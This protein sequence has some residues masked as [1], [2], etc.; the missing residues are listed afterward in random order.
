MGTDPG[1]NLGMAP[2][3]S[4]GKDLGLRMDKDPDWKEGKVAGLKD[5]DP[6]RRAD[7]VYYHP[8]NFHLESL[9]DHIHV[10]NILLPTETGMHWVQHFPPCLHSVST[11]LCSSVQ[12]LQPIS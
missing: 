11:D 6:G 2:E 7:T 5:M 3:W 4:E 9:V 12:D 1:E 8:H 10:P